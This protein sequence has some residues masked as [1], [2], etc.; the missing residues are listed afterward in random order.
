MNKSYFYQLLL[1]LLLL[2]IF[3]LSVTAAEPNPTTLK[4]GLFNLLKPKTI[5][6][7]TVTDEIIAIKSQENSKEIPSKI[8]SLNQSLTLVAKANKITCYLKNSQKT[9]IKKWEVE[10]LSLSGSNSL[11]LFVA[12]RL[13]R[14]IP[15]QVSFYAKNDLLYTTLLT[16]LEETTKIALASEVAEIS[17]INDTQ[18]LA[19]F[20]AFAIVVRSYIESEKGRHRQDGYD[21]C[22]NTH[23]LLYLDFNM[24]KSLNTGMIFLLYIF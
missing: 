9:V 12:N 11:S 22:D 4:L 16:N 6:I 7:E 10:Q 17:N 20:K 5:D 3:T 14:Q 13:R 23:C 24:F 8:L 2:L 21:I 19:I 15:A 1:P 18:A